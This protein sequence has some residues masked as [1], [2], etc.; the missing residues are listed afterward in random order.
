MEQPT[1]TEEE[2]INSRN[3]LVKYLIAS[4]VWIYISGILLYSAITISNEQYEV[5][6][7]Q[8]NTIVTLTSTV[9]TQSKQID[10][11]EKRIIKNP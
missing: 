5:I 1:K 4:I 3:R 2:L 9:I 10:K 7:N 8:K 11:L 6:D